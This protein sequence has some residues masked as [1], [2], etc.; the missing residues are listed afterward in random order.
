V[1][2]SL[3]FGLVTPPGSDLTWEDAVRD[4]IAAAPEVEALGYDGLHVVEH[5]FQPDGYNPSPLLTLAAAA[6]VT[7]RIELATNILLVPLYAPV[8]LA[9]DVAVLDNLC[10]GRLRLGVAPGYVRE[11]F[12]GHGVP[13]EERF[14]RFEE[15]L[16]L[17]QLAWRGEPFAWE[18]ECFRVPETRL[19]PAPVQPGGPPLWYGVSGPRMLRRAARR[20]AALAMSPRHGL[21]E[22]RE[23]VAR[24]EADAAEAGVPLAPE[25]IAMREVFLA[26]TRA[27]AERIA[28]P[29][30]THL[31]R[32]LYGRRSAAGERVLRN[33]AGEPV[34]D[35]ATVDFETFKARYMIGTPDDA[36]AELAALRDELGVTEVSC[37]MHLPGIAGEDAMRSARLFASEVIPRLRD[38]PAVHDQPRETA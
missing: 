32:E 19:A 26:E 1:R 2:F 36:L 23:H 27:E 38:A 29:A 13:Y 20:G 30:V 37:W 28:A 17:M 12:A 14:R 7:K 24:F 18:G 22:L 34:T 4:L 10:G 9:E 16:D 6:G 31:F 3:G 21:A 11:E 5:H 8:K 35:H 33:D 25:R 15:A